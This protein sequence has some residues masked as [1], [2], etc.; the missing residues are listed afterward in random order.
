VQSGIN[1]EKKGGH[2]QRTGKIDTNKMAV[3]MIMTHD[4]ERRELGEMGTKFD[5]EMGIA[6]CSDPNPCA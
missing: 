4:R 3:P 2:K 1:L 5:K 6:G